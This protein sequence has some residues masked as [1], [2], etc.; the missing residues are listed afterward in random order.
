MSQS[1]LPAGVRARRMDDGSRTVTD[2]D[3]VQ[4]V[5]DAVDD[6][7]CRTILEATRDDTLSVSEIAESCDLAQSTAYRKVDILADA[8]LLEETLR[9]RQSGKHVSEYACGVADV[10]LD[11]TADD[12]IRLTV[13]R[14]STPA[15][16][17]LEGT[18]GAQAPADD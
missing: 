9:I 12:G 5:L 13:E 14:A 15:S 18:F 16:A 11:I 2:S 3:E 8:D 4:D 6:S 10:T 7:D 1:Q 17:T